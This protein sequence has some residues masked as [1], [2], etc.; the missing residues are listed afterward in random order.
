ME[1][2]EE[3]MARLW[4]NWAARFRSGERARRWRRS[5]GNG[6]AAAL[7]LRSYR[8]AEEMEM[9]LVSWLTGALSELK[10]WPAVPGRPRRVAA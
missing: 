1:V 6:G 9:G 10:S 2:V 3:I 5:V 4:A 7:L 8:R